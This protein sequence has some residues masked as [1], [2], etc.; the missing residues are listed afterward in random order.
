MIIFLLPIIFAYLFE[1]LYCINWKPVTQYDTHLPYFE[2]PV[3]VD[4][5]IK[6]INNLYIKE[7]HNSNIKINTRQSVYTSI[8]FVESFDNQRLKNDFTWFKRYH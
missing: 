1:T 5:Y 3:I 6:Y 7:K 8:Q 2:S 4:L